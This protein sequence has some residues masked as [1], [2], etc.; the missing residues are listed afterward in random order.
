MSNLPQ[1]SG[2]NPQQQQP[3]IQPVHPQ[4]VNPIQPVIPQQEG[5]DIYQGEQRPPQQEQPQTHPVQPE[6]PSRTPQQPQQPTG[7]IQTH[8]EG[9]PVQPQPVVPQPVKLD[10]ESLAA[11]TE[12]A[13]PAQP[14]ATDPGAQKRLEEMS[15]EEIQQILAD[16]NVTPWQATREFVATISGQELED[17]TDKQINAYQE[18]YNSAVNHG[19]TMASLV[20]GQQN[21]DV[22]A[23][24]E[25][26][27]R[28]YSAQEQKSAFD[29]F[30]SAFPNLKQHSRAVV[31]AAGDLQKAVRSGQV[32]A[33]QGDMATYQALANQT[34]SILHELGVQ[35]QPNVQPGGVVPFQQAQPQ[36]GYTGPV[37]SVGV[38][39]MAAGITP[40]RS[41]QGGIV[42]QPNNPDAD[43]YGK[44]G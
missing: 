26:L 22:M 21:Q 16:N 7:P 44:S 27:E 14:Q 37:A 36:Q 8:P 25:P 5:G 11:I 41:Q 32:A 38:P 24:V 9:Q 2:S 39:T 1:D 28:H 3:L 20:S 12:A 19:L 35:V 10:A 23:R 18:M 30:Y 31:M 29:G 6:D 43:I 33:P 42:G 15:P 13:K 34:V 40:G 17:I 4:P